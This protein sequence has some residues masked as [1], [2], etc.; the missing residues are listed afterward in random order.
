MV[1]K[2]TQIA[3]EKKLAEQATQGELK[4]APAAE[5]GG[6]ACLRI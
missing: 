5:M 1:Q 4:T 3:G 6:V 2:A